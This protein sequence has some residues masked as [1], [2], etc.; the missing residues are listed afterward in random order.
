MDLTTRERVSSILFGGTIDANAEPGDAQSIAL[1]V[2]VESVSAACERYLDRY[3]QSGISRTE[4]LNVEGGQTL[5][6]LRAYPVASVTGVWFDLNQT[7]AA[8]TQL[9]STDYFSPIIDE[10]G[11]LR[12]RYTLLDDWYQIPAPATLK[13]TYTGGMAASTQ[14]FIATYPDLASAI[15]RQVIYEFK[16][17]NDPGS[18]SISSEAGS[19]AIPEVHLLRSTI[20][21]LDRHR[22][23]THG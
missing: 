19:V 23:T 18:L 11:L 14:A 10:R 22:R 3:V 12:L 15:D 20:E 21:A 7:F 17:K 16:R 1:L 9:S 4:Y 6:T 8:S 2:L 13:V 5:F